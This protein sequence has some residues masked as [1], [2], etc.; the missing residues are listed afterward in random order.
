MI[1]APQLNLNTGKR[2]WPSL[3]CKFTHHHTLKRIYQ[4]YFL[5]IFSVLA[6]LHFIKY[7]QLSRLDQI[8]LTEVLFDYIKMKQFLI[9][10][11]EPQMGLFV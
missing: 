8:I 11:S 5:T 9:E 2:E 10:K 4:K 1:L 3:M 6:N 7:Y